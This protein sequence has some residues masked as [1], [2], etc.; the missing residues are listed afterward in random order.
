L[1]SAKAN[2][3]ASLAAQKDGKMTV[4]S[5]CYW[6]SSCPNQDHCCSRKTKRTAKMATKMARMEEKTVR[7]SFSMLRVNIVEIK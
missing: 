1:L 4:F 6:M 3:A 2:Q 7:R 5:F